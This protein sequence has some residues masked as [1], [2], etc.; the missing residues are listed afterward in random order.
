MSLRTRRGL[1]LLLALLFVA[2]ACTPAAP[3]GTPQATPAQPGET[4]GQP[5]DTPDPGTETPDPG[6]ETPDPGTESPDPGTESP[7]PGQPTEGGSIVIGEWQLPTTVNPYASSAWVTQQAAAPHF[8]SGM[9][10]DDQ[11][12]WLPYL[13]S[14]TPVAEATDDGGMTVTMRIKD[15]LTWSDGE[16]LDG[17]DWVYTYEWAQ[18]MVET[19]QCGGCG[20]LAIRLPD[21]SDYYITEHQVSDDGLEVTWTWQE[22][23][24][25]WMGWAA[26]APMPEQFFGMEEWID[27]PLDANLANV[28]ASGPFIFTGA[29]ANRIDYAR[30]DQFTAFEGPYLDSLIRIYYPGS[31]DS[32][33]AAFLTGEV[34]QIMN[35][36]MADYEA[37]Q[38]Q[39]SADVGRVEAIPA[40]LYE[41]LEINTEREQKGL[42]DPN[43][44]RAIHMAI[45]KQELWETLFPGTEYTEAC[46]NAP[47]SAWWYDPSIE[48]PPYDP[49]GARALLEEAGWTGTPRTHDG[50]TP[51]DPADDRTMELQLCTTIGNPTRLLTLG[52]IAQFLAAVGIPATIETQDAA[53]YFADYP[54]ITDDTVCGLSR[55]NYDISLFTYLL[56]DP[57]GF[58]YGT[59][60]SSN[61]PPNGFQS[62]WTRIADEELD[63]ALDALNEAITEDEILERSAEVNR[64]LVELMPEIPLYYRNEVAGISN[65]LGNMKMNPSLFGPVWN[66]HEWYVQ[67]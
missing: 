32:M 51:D 56:A 39:L 46:T 65:R 53:V 25:G 34:D 3:T 63:A 30:N 44:R 57:G 23:Y 38:G 47:S 42:D 20:G 29:G 55:G 35:M 61:V 5:V 41:H 10:I 2:A 6:T 21:D 43:V 66:V 8:A 67:E 14:E 1:A 31:K 16:T 64:L 48:C 62:N 37:I 28:P 36:T 58:Y 9:V 24:S 15:G 7:D 59:F 40:W 19:G 13:L 33:I 26:F 54:D 45:N 11:G 18:A 50:G 4:P 60:H 49:D 12:Q 17:N 22:P 27:L 52:K